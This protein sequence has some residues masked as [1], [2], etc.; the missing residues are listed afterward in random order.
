MIADLGA[1]LPGAGM[2]AVVKDG[3]GLLPG[4]AGGGRAVRN[5]VGVAE[6]NE[7]GG[8]E[9]DLFDALADAESLPVAG[10]RLTVAAEVMVRVA[11]AVE[12]GSH[13]APQV[14]VIGMAEELEG[15]L[16]GGQA[17]LVASEHDMV[18]ADAV[19]CVGLPGVVAGSLVDPERALGPG[20]RLGGLPQLAESRREAQLSFGLVDPVAGLAEQVHCPLKMVA[21]ICVAPSG[22]QD[23]A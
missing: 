22:E 8:L 10:D 18:P 12:R 19:E 23:L 11:D 13:Y 17:V 9:P 14:G 2:A 3:Q 15:V 1:Y 6:M 5:E 7:G 16:A 4:V 21:G 20:E